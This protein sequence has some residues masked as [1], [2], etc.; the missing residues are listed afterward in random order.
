MKCFEEEV[1]EVSEAE[2]EEDNLS[3]KPPLNALSV[4]N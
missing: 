2:E 3:I 1:V 4:T